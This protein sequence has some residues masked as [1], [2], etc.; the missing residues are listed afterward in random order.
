MA[1]NVSLNPEHMKGQITTNA[2][3]VVSWY[4]TTV[5]QYDI[6]QKIGEVSTILTFTLSS[7]SILAESL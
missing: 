2:I 7:E 4:F 6:F 1:V 3:P 5:S